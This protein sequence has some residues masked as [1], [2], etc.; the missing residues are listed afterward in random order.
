MQNEYPAERFD[1][2]ASDYDRTLH[3]WTGFPFEDYGGVLDAVVREADVRPGM[4]VIDLGVGTGNLAALFLDLG[5]AVWGTD[6]SAKMLELTRKK[7]PGIHLV[8]ADLLGDW[9]GIDRRFDRVVSSFV[10]HHFDLA[11]KIKLIQRIARDYL[12]HDGRLVIADVSF[13]TEDA[14]IEGSK[15]FGP[16]WDQNECYWVAD[17]A[18]KALGEQGLACRYRQ[19]TS[20]GGVFVVANG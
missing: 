18:I 9:P 10:F 1:E 19:V 20:C 17:E 5:C 2:M 8:Q 12:A 15:R 11:T 13:P 7:C 16:D 6:F 3:E 4:T 14:R